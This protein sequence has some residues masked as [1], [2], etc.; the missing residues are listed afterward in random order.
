[1]TVQDTRTLCRFIAL[2]IHQMSFT[3]LVMKR[4]TAKIS[5]YSNTGFPTITSMKLI[6]TASSI[7]SQIQTT[8]KLVHS[9]KFS[10]LTYIQNSSVLTS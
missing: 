10:V 5:Y 3:L 9:E 1:M 6:S 7:I 8:I 4:E 2:S